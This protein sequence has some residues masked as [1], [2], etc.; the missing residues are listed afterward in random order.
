MSGA[1]GGTGATTGQGGTTGVGTN[2]GAAGE[3]G[4]GQGGSGGSSS[5]A[6][7]STRAAAPTLPLATELDP[8]QVALAAA[9]IGSCWDDDGVNR[10]ASHLW[11]ANLAAGRFYYRTATELACVVNAGCGCDAIDH[12]FG[13]DIG[14]SAACES[15]CEDGIFTG[16][17]RDIGL[18]D[19]Y[20]ATFDCNSVGLACDTTALCVDGPTTACDSATF[21]AGCTADGRPEFCDDGVVWHGQTCDALGLSCV[22]GA[23]VGK[24]ADCE[25][26]LGDGEVIEFDGVGCAGDTLE[27]CV[28]GKSATLD[29]TTQGPGFGCQEQDGAFFCGLASECV[30]AAEGFDSSF[31]ASCD[32][33]VLTFCNAGRI[34]H[35]ECTSLGFTGCDIDHAKGHYGCVPRQ[36]E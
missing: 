36:F 7:H 21:V 27:A 20:R 25:T 5:T 6:C 12:C 4:A 35:V 34:E 22:G 28:G 23:C 32:G 8:D 19:G 3:A 24:G 29:C 1:A 26:F 33:S 9:V 14:P 31:A 10:N 2:A 16:C 11:H 15:S 13:F 30:P 17:G 18:A